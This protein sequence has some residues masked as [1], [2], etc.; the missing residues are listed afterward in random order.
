MCVLL[1][2]VFAVFLH[3]LVGGEGTKWVPGMALVALLPVPG[4]LIVVA[5]HSAVTLTRPTAPERKV[6][7]I[8]VMTDTLT[9]TISKY[10]IIV[11]VALAVRRELRY[12]T[13]VIQ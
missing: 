7:L 2:K 9:F 4:R 6:E 3:D 5:V 8:V 13:S 12:C 10:N 11:N 1:L